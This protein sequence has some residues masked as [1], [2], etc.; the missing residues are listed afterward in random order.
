MR[1]ASGRQI[2]DAR[3]AEVTEIDKDFPAISMTS[4]SSDIMSSMAF[5]KPCHI[6]VNLRLPVS[7]IYLLDKMSRQIIQA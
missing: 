4:G 5:V 6:S 7:R 2:I 1:L 3:R